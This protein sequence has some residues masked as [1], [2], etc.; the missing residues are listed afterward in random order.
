MQPKPSSMLRLQDYHIKMWFN[1]LGIRHDE[2]R[3]DY[4]L[5]PPKQLKLVELMKL[6]NDK[7]LSEWALRLENTQVKKQVFY[8]DLC[9]FESQ[10][11]EWKKL[12]QI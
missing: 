8:R 9:R 5:D 2:D 7:A 1:E 12:P 6:A 4:H 10:V 3:T 11:D